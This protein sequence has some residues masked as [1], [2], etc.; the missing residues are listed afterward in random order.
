MDLIFCIGILSLHSDLE[1]S[2]CDANVLLQFKRTDIVWDIVIFVYTFLQKQIVHTLHDEFLPWVS[3][4]HAELEAGCHGTGL[5]FDARGQ[6]ELY[7]TMES[8]FSWNLP[9]EMPRAIGTFGIFVLN[10]CRAATDSTSA[11]GTG[12]RCRARVSHAQSHP[13]A[14]G[15]RH[16]SSTAVPRQWAF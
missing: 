3:S 8:A 15:R 6:L 13:A 9:V 4:S 16:C 2:L 5:I 14:G 12:L 1:M 10:T 7:L 11:H